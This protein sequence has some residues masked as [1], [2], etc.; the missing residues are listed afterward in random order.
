MSFTDSIDLLNT[1]LKPKTEKLFDFKS[2]SLCKA[3]YRLD[4][5]E[6]KIDISATGSLKKLTNS[7]YDELPNEKFLKGADIKQWEDEFK[8]VTKLIKNKFIKLDNPIFKSIFFKVDYA[9]NQ[10]F[11]QFFYYGNKGELNKSDAIY[12]VINK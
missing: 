8:M 3:F 4:V 7:V 11:L 5:V 6:G 12:G 2:D 9:E 10:T 1:V